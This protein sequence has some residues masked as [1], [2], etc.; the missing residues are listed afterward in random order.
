MELCV[1]CRFNLDTR[2]MEEGCLNL[3]APGAQIL[4]QLCLNIE[5]S[6]SQLLWTEILDLNISILFCSWWMDLQLPTGLI[7]V[8]AI[9]RT[10]FLSRCFSCYLRRAAI[11]N[12]TRHVKKE[13]LDVKGIYAEGSLTIIRS[14]KRFNLLEA[15]VRHSLM[16]FS[17][18]C[19]NAT[20]PLSACTSRVEEEKNP[21]RLFFERKMIRQEA[22]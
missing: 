14:V 13:V 20:R 10:V 5:L 8:S 16:C 11:N 19:L 1:I 21:K 18:G 12:W 9:A 17:W 22:S 7:S 6:R 15:C 2:E 4:A 3:I